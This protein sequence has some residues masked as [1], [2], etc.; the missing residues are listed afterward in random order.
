M[1]SDMEALVESKSLKPWLNEFGEELPISVLRQKSREW[2]KGTWNLYLESIEQNPKEKLVSPARLNR[3]S[4][5]MRE[6][7]F[8]H[9]ASGHTKNSSEINQ[10]LAG[11]TARQ[12]QIIEMTYWQNMSQRKIA[13][14]LKLNQATVGEIKQS[15]IR[16]LREL[17]N[18]NPVTLP[19]CK[20]ANV[21]ER[22]EKSNVKVSA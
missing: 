4:A 20:G 5:K 13:K 19:M 10:L 2:D 17:A 16:K 1:A 22:K 14:A 3:E 18:R 11:L 8:A 12:R 9:A 7:L 15:A 6:S 21:N